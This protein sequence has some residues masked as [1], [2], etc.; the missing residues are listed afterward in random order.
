MGEFERV[1]REIVREELAAAQGVPAACSLS[2]KSIGAAVRAEA[3]RAGKNHSEL[4]EAL[5]VSR[6]T[7]AGRLSGAYEFKQGELEKISDLLGITPYNIIES[8]GLGQRFHSE[9][10]DQSEV[11]RVF[12]RDAWAQ[13]S[14]ARA[15][16][17]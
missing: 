12:N 10:A 2:A 8:A 17:E 13:P 9:T 14:R 15:R 7:I 16:R 4:A 3:A 6:P 11:A 5:G 1:V